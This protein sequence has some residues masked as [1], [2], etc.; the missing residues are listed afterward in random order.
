[1][2]RAPRGCRSDNRAAGVRIDRNINVDLA[3]FFG[4]VDQL[5]Q[6]LGDLLAAELTAK[7][8]QHP[9]DNAAEQGAEARHH[10]T[11]GCPEGAAAERPAECTE[12]TAY[13]SGFFRAR[14]IIRQSSPADRRSGDQRAEDRH[15]RKKPFKATY[16]TAL[17]QRCEP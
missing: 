14:E 13:A 5:G 12:V 1:A 6:Q 16:R 7:A 8:A 3:V 10:A 4:D 9:A 2:P 15:T 11:D 17:E